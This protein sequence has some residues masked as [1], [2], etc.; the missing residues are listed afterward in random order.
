MRN[1][2]LHILTFPNAPFVDACILSK[3][4][5]LGCLSGCY[6]S[7]LSLR[8]SLYPEWTYSMMGVNLKSHLITLL[9]LLFQKHFDFSFPSPLSSPA[10]LKGLLRIAKGA[11]RL[12][13]QILQRFTFCVRYICNSCVVVLILLM[14]SFIVLFR[15]CW[16]L[17][18]V[19]FL[20]T[21]CLPAFFFS[22]H[23]AYSFSLVFVLLRGSCE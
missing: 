6:C 12:T 16:C 2:M 8:L 17:T 5:N 9:K 14:V 11:R 18:R 22:S 1:F 15:V 23:G 21:Q 20:C 3:V 10:A 7:C 19:S 4:P 13:E